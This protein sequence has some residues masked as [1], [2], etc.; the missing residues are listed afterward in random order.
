[1]NT[2]DYHKIFKISFAT[3]LINKL[4]ERGLI[5]NRGSHKVNGQKLADEIGVSLPM[6]RRYINAKSIPENSTLQKIANW[7]G[8]DPIWLLYGDNRE[9]ESSCKKIN[10]DL[11]YE[12]FKH[13]YEQIC[14]SS[15]TKEKYMIIIN[16]CIDIYCH[17]SNMEE[18]KPKD[19]A[20]RLMVNFLKN[21]L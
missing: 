7:L 2:P 9:E 14:S 6:A 21:K 10:K 13:F 8:V 5:S 20:I 3:R 19:N 18:N 1:M 16:G 4:K 11:F 15:L 12:I 17:I